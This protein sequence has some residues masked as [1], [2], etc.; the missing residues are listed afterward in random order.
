MRSPLQ[1]NH[2]RYLST[3]WGFSL[4]IFL[5]YAAFRPTGKLADGI[6]NIVLV[7]VGMSGRVPCASLPISFAAP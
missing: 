3:L 1:V 2:T 7:P 5:R 6:K 4:A